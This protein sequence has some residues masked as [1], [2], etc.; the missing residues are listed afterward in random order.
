M[1]AMAAPRVAWLDMA[2]GLCMVLVVL[3][4]ADIASGR[5]HEQS[6]VAC[7]INMALVPLRLPLFFLVSGLLAAR[8]LSRSPRE[9]LVRRVLFCLY[10][11]VLW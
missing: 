2:R 10:L 11:Y 5:P 8:L 7:L 9:V 4:H 6:A 1:S 3:L